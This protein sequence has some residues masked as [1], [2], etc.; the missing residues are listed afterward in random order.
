MQCRHELAV[1]LK[2]GVWFG[3][4]GEHARFMVIAHLVECKRTADHVA[5]EPLTSFGIGG[6]A[7]DVHGEARA[8]PLA[9]A[10][11]VM[12]NEGA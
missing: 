1:A 3:A 4:I 8:S 9:H 5:G 2:R 10:M 6:L 12:G 7:A 11:G